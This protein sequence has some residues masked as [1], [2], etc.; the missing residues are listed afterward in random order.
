MSALPVYLS[1]LGGL[2]VDRQGPTMKTRCSG[3][4]SGRVAVHGDIVLVGID[5]TFTLDGKL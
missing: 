5:E 4:D 2:T 1:Q 3:F